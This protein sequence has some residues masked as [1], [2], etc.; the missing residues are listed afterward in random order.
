MVTRAREQASDLVALLEEQGACCLEFSTIAVRPLDDYAEVEE[1]ILRLPDYDWIVFTS[2]NG[3][4]HFWTELEEIGLDTRMLGGI[5]VAAIGPATAEAL[6]QRGVHPDFIPDTYVAESVAQGL[7]ELGVAGKHILIPRA[8]EAREVL[9]EELRKAGAIV[10]VLPVYEAA[11]SGAPEQRDQLLEQLAAGEIH[12][13]TFASSST[14]DNFF[15][16]VHPDQHQA[17]Q[18]PDQAGLHRADH[19]QDPGRI[20]LPDRYPTNGIHHPGPGCSHGPGRAKEQEKGRGETLLKERFPPE[21]PSGNFIW[22]KT[23]ISS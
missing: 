13:I 10:D 4:C 15:A 21:H 11:P 19:G 16:L 20:R 5:H 22:E 17:V 12:Y 1:A 18:E 23:C 9:P 14:V 3:V 2:V 6:R 7:M 8:R